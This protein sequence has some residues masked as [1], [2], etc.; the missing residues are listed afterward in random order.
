MN[1]GTFNKLSAILNGNNKLIIPDL[2]R[3]YCWGI[4]KTSGANLS[5]A[6]VFTQELLAESEKELTDATH[7]YGIIYTYEYPETFLYLCDGQQRLTTLYLILGVLHCYS[8]DVRIQSMLRL[9]NGQ[10]RLKY[11]VRSTT[12]Y[13]L[14]NLL[15]EVFLK[16]DLTNM[17]DISKTNWFRRQYYDDPSIDNI[18]EALRQIHALINKE[19]AKKLQDF[20]LEKIGFVYLKLEANETIE[21]KTYSKIR[22]YGE[23][24]YE[25]VNTCGDPMEFN[26]H[27]K[28]SLLAKLD[29]ESR[30]IWTE[31][32]ELWQ[33]FFWIYKGKNESADVGFN[34]FL[35]WLKKVDSNAL[36]NIE[37]IEPYFKAF[38][39]LINTQSEI[40]D[41]RTF[42]ILN[43]KKEFVANRQL[44]EVVLFPCLVYLKDT[45][46]VKYDK[47]RY[48]V[49]PN[50][51]NYDDL[52]RFIR[53]F[54]NLARN[55]KKISSDWNW[56]NSMGNNRDVIHFLNLNDIPPSILTPEERF[57]LYLYKGCEDDK[58]RKEYENK[59]WKAE[60]HKYLNG[61]INPIFR[62][63][64][65]D[66]DSKG[67]SFD[68]D[69][70][71][72]YYND[73]DKVVEKEIDML[74]ITLFAV[75]DDWYEYRDGLSW[76]VLRYYLG[77]KDD[78]S[79]WIDSVKH[80]TFKIIMER[81]S[82][83]KTLLEI[84]NEKINE[85]GY[86][87]KKK[88]VI[89][90]LRDKANKYWQWKDNYRFFIIDNKMYLPNR[91]K[92]GTNTD[93]ID[94]L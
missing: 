62:W 82:K 45:L 87:E 12:D 68:L 4:T 43:I 15:G 52:F 78:N 63:M 41:F 29:A 36:E 42:Q 71:E 3:D 8:Q 25:I 59:I 2:Q 10:A 70:F 19:N 74:R 91:T 9:E 23:K 51:I 26:E 84:L 46:A 47:D 66:M 17:K 89:C 39:L 80:G 60:D 35:S 61:Q 50:E 20:L 75:H 81:Y 58:Q 69:M 34:M 33:D 7:S 72:T 53:F 38:F 90:L 14:Q 49:E 57:K 94:I 48:I 18:K 40:S 21:S 54:S 24:M 56:L 16:S 28:S 77:K 37:T 5:L 27:L 30:E 76:G 65:I 73:L 22:E 85:E 55:A 64:G 86:E 1:Q 31:K 11:E 83:G 67:D 92:A 93:G 44:D 88:K 13:F 32:W 6:G 79:F